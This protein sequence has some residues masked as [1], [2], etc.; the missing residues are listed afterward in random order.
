MATVHLSLLFLC[1][2][3]MEACFHQSIKE[4]K[5]GKF[6]LSYNSDYFLLHVIHF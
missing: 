3:F 1:P 6:D 4:S 2:A 5:K